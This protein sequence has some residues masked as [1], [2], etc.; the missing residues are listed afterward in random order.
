ME[1]SNTNPSLSSIPRYRAHCEGARDA[2]RRPCQ[3][4]SSTPTDVGYARICAVTCRIWSGKRYQAALPD[5][6]DPAPDFVTDPR[7][8]YDSGRVLPSQSSAWYTPQGC[9]AASSCASA[10]WATLS[11]LVPAAE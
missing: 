6:I 1:Q 10:C 5:V 2:I 4:C 3:S 9:F 11:V 7:F 8:L